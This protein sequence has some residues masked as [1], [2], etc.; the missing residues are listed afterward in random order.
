MIR[1]RWYSAQIAKLVGISEN[2][3]RDYFELYQAGGV[4]GLKRVNWT[5]TSPP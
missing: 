4:E 2:T 3:L 1:S 5:P